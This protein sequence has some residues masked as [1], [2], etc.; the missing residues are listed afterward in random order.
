RAQRN[1]AGHRL[2]PWLGHLMVSRQETARPLLTPGEVMQLPPDESVV[3]VSSVAPIKAKKLRYYQDANF[4]RRVLV[5]PVLA[6]GHYAD[7]PPARSDDWS[8]LAIP[9]MPA[10]SVSASVDD[11]TDSTG[12]GPR[13]QPELSETVAY[14]PELDSSTS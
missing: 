11:L 10:V 12:G 7:A 9:A 8:D 3:M 13:Q 14:N 4:S 5:P 1:Y 6:A 2:A